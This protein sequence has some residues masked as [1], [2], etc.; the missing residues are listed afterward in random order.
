MI[1]WGQHGDFPALIWGFVDLLTVIPEGTSVK[2]RNGSV[3]QKG[4]WAV[5]E[6]TL[7]NNTREGGDIFKHI[8]L[9]TKSVDGNG[10]PTE[11]KFYLVDVETFK[12]PLVVIPNVGT[13]CDYLLMTPKAQWGKLFEGWIMG[14]H[15]TDE[16]EMEDTEEEEVEEKEEAPEEEEAQDDDDNDSSDG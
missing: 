13:K 7:L 2:L 9:E 14:P 3:V 4:V 1:D 15:A 16:A 8:T 6:S 11:R 12:S 5:I 10:Y